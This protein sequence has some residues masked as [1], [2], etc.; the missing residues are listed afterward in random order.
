MKKKIISVF[1]AITLLLSVAVTIA[2]A[3][4]GKLGDMDDNGD[5]TA[6]DARIILR[7]AARL[8]KLDED[9]AKRADTNRDGILTAADARLTLRVAA[10][11]D[12]FGEEPTEEQPSETEPQPVS[13]PD[14]VQAFMD[15]KYYINGI[16]NTSGSVSVSGTDLLNIKMAV[17]GNNFEI[18][19][20]ETDPVRLS[21]ATLRGKKYLKTIDEKGRKMY[22]EL[23][24]DLI[25]FINTV[26][27]ADVQFDSLILD[28]NFNKFADLSTPEIN[29]NTYTFNAGKNKI[30]FYVEKEVVKKID[31]TDSQGENTTITVLSMTSAI[32]SDML[33][34]NGFAEKTIL[35]IAEAFA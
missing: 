1:L 17:D 8:E 7:A 24:K 4:G 34:V 30:S 22:T 35:E 11:L 33:T 20:D 19:M 13:Y 9:H 26:L 12:T 10:Q 21:L 18:I 5:I 29:G 3:S 2:F 28:V 23:T 15:G 16:V 25:D 31:I 27:N 14:A 32:P 6:A